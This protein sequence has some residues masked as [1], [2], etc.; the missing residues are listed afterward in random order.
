MATTH[1]LSD[2]LQKIETEID[3]YYKSNPLLKLPFATAV[4]HLLAVAENDALRQ[5]L[6]GIDNINNIHALAGEFS[7]NLEHSMSWLY[8]ACDCSG[9]VSSVYDANLRQASQDLF[10]LG[11]KYACFDFTYRCARRGVIALTPQGATIQPTGDILEDLEFEAYN[12]LIDFYHAAEPLSFTNLEN[13]PKDAIE[14]S[15]SMVG[16][17]FRYKLNRRLVSDMMK[18][19]RPF[20]DRMFSL[21]SEWQFSRYSLGNF[22]KVFEVICAIS[23]IHFT[24]RIIAMNRGC[25]DLGYADSIYMPTYIE[26]LTRVV[27]YSR[28]PKATVQNILDDLTYGN[29]GILHPAPAL[30]PLIKLNS[31]IYAIVPHLWI[32]SAA[33]VNFT[34]LLNKLPSE[35]HIYS[36]L[37]TEK[38]GLM[39]KRIKAR[40]SG[41]GFRTVSGEI[42]GLP[43]IDLAI[44]MDSE[45]TCLLLELK[46]FIA[47]ALARERI[48]KSEEIAKGVSQVTRLK[49]AFANN[50]EPL[51]NK[52]KIDSS[53]RLEGVVVSE[54]WIGY[55][56]VQSPEVPVIQSD[57]LIAKLR[58]AQNLESAVEW[59]KARKYLPKEGEH[60][61]V[62]QETVT[63]GDWTL[64]APTIEFLSDEPFFPL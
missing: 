7:V 64:N 46:W 28:V 31:D 58:T 57:H 63:I 18:Y 16:N 4:W 40:L 5:E 37:A 43:D 30:Q 11:K 10:E 53:Y 3:N 22:R 36:K 42:P 59:L 17:G 21:P 13:F 29:G 12:I 6:G 38:E 44:I 14:R 60:F 1:T 41:K 50:H 39:R 26:L 52:L 19:L 35:K 15:L 54:N 20:L 61:K 2:E 23:H 27:N 56:D 45:K 33:E 32:S 34:M 51:L 48:E 8:G 47:P 55:A 25:K 24:A 62:I 9:Q 49:Q